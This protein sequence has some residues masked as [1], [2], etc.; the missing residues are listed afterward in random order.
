MTMAFRSAGVQL[1]AVGGG[2]VF[3]A[4]RLRTN[5]LFGQNQNQFVAQRFLQQQQDTNSVSAKV[6]FTF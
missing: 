6:T 2:H 1:K 3:R 4:S 5:N